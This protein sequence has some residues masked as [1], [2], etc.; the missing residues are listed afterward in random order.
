MKVRLLCTCLLVLLFASCGE[1]NKILKSPDGELRYEYAK[2]YFDEGK[3]GRSITLLESIMT[4]YVGSSKEQEIMYLLAQSYFFDKDYTMS[5]YYYT[6]YFNKFPRG[7]YAELARFNAAE[8]LYRESPDPRLDQTSTVKAIQGFQDFLEYFP[9]SDKAQDAQEKMFEL[10]EKLAFKELRTARL[11]FNLGTYM[12]NN[13]ESCVITSRE[14][15]RTYPFSAYT[16]EFQVLIL[17]SKYE[18]A[19]NSVDEKKESR[20][21]EI[22]DEHFNYKNLYPEGKYLKESEKY[23]KKALDELGR[24]P[25]DQPT[26]APAKILG[27]AEKEEVK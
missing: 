15:L 10:Q 8:G 18:E 1:Y 26:S 20:Y 12:G 23:Y 25:D 17:R 27:K 3:Y 7:E 16:E 6:H 22:I 5:T 2:K 13:Y 4:S 19:M 24:T 21:Y 11:Y 14:A 9:Q